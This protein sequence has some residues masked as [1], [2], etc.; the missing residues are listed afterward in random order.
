[1]LN[2]NWRGLFLGGVTASLIIGLAEFLQAIV[3][4]GEWAEAMKRLG[5]P[6]ELTAAQSIAMLPWV[7]V[8]GSAIVWLAAA[9]EPRFVKPRSAALCAGSF[10]WLFAYGVAML[11]PLVLGVLPL[12]LG[13]IWVSIGIVEALLAALGGS[14]VYH[15][16]N[17]SWHEQLRPQG[18][19][20]SP[21]H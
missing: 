2:L 8:T 21:A 15:Q 1:M 18:G 12:R 10:V 16:T 6:G 19:V 3:W 9:L 20:E 4:G 17:P 11:A 13:L 7:L 14:L 5:L